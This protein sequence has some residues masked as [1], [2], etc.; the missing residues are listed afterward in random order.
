MVK[1][2]EFGRINY[3]GTGR[4]Y[5]VTVRIAL[6]KRGGEDVFTLQNGVKV[7]TGE[8]TPEYYEFT[9]S[10]MIGARCVGQCLD[11]IAKHC[12]NST[13]MAIYRL[14]Q[15][16]HLNGM[17]AGT[18]EQEKALERWKNAGNKYNYDGACEYL[19]SC[20]LYEVNYTGKTTGRMY[21]NEPYKYGHAWIVND[22]PADDLQKI[23][24]LFEMEA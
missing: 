22:I 12:K 16:Y 8:K 10:G 11:E 6:E 18:P 1:K 14:W 4:R 20:G 17:H 13:F 7:Y 9:A 19:K 5:P 2:F 23:N 3:N 15:K 21:N 24:N